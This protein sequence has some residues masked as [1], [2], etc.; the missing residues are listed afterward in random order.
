MIINEFDD[1]IDLKSYNSQ[2]K[3]TYKIKDICRYFNVNNKL[4]I[5][6][7]YD[8]NNKDDFKVDEKLTINYG[9]VHIIE[10]LKLL[11]DYATYNIDNSVIKINILN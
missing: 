6:N 8:C 4:E 7:R 2:N 3:E 9:I 1:K 11:D 10:I 5:T